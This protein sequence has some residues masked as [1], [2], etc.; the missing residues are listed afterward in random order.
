MDLLNDIKYS[1]ITSKGDVR[2]DLEYSE[3]ILNDKLNEIDRIEESNIILNKY[4]YISKLMQNGFI[5]LQGEYTPGSIIK[6]INPSE[7]ALDIKANPIVYSQQ[8]IYNNLSTEERVHGNELLGTLYPNNSYVKLFV[9][10]NPNI[11]M[12]MDSNGFE[13]NSKYMKALTHR[14]KISDL[15]GYLNTNDT[16]PCWME[17]KGSLC[18][19]SDDNPKLI[20]DP[21][22]GDY[23]NFENPT[24]YLELKKHE[25]KQ[26][27]TYIF[28]ARCHMKA[29]IMFLGTNEISQAT[30]RCLMNKEGKLEMYGGKVIT[31]SDDTI[32]REY[33]HIFEFV[34]NHDKSTIYVD[35]GRLSLTNND[36]GVN[37]IITGI[38]LG[39]TYTKSIAQSLDIKEFVMV[40]GL[41]DDTTREV[42]VT[43]YKNVYR[44]PWRLSNG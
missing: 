19:K 28:I 4:N 14:F 23:I 6:L 8:I 7:F 40:D 10:E 15:G 11:F 27:N 31:Q 17:H 9:T 2:T 44:I 34:F 35:G 42:I 25:I 5:M 22:H 1:A 18:F 37:D 26:P 43:N 30:Q 33:F 16:I 21:L 41:L 24:M 12:V 20:K 39:N 29:K 32:Y 3:H 36:V 38:I 13:L